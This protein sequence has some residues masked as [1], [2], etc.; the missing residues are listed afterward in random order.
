MFSYT[1]AIEARAL[2]E[3]AEGGQP[4][5]LIDVRGSREY[6]DGHAKRAISMPLDKLEPNHITAV[7][8]RGAGTTEP[9]YLICT[10][11]IRAEQAAHKLKTLG[12][13][14]LML[15]DGGMQSWQSS[16]LPMLRTSR[17]PSLESQA[18]IAVGILLLAILAKAMLLHPVFYALI[19]VVGAGMIAAGINARR[20]LTAL[21]S[22]MPWN[23]TPSMDLSTSG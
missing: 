5:H 22:R 7:F 13:D 6:A 9:V 18:Q 20:P 12:L 17:I 10:S 16:G 15:V 21:I 2:H 3:A 23:R 11:G 14:N 8:G 1:P 19:A 4:V